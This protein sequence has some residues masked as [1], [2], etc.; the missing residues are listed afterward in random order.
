[1][2]IHNISFLTCGIGMHIELH[3][4]AD[5]KD[6]ILTAKEDIITAGTFLHGI[7]NGEFYFSLYQAL[8]CLRYGED[9]SKLSDIHWLALKVTFSHFT[10][11]FEDSTS[12]HDEFLLH[13]LFRSLKADKKNH[14]KFKDIDENGGKDSSPGWYELSKDKDWQDFT[15]KDWSKCV[16]YIKAVLYPAE[17][18]AE[19]PIPNFSLYEEL[20]PH[21]PTIQEYRR[22]MTWLEYEYDRLNDHYKEFQKMFADE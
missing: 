12:K 19:Y 16:L 10:I 22:A 18:E 11:L 5:E 4:S 15:F 20:D 13:H 3:Q 17:L 9:K 2:N 14:K 6:L 1:M 7:T 21:M 8:T